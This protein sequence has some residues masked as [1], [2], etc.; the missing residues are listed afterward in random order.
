MKQEP[1]KIGWLLFLF[2]VIAYLLFLGERPI[3]RFD[4][5]RYAEIPREMIESSD[6]V[7]P[8]LNGVRYFEKPTLGYWLTALSIQLFG[9]N[10]FALRLVP[11]LSAGV[12]ALAVFWIASLQGIGGRLL[13]FASAAVLLSSPMFFALGTLNLLDMPL[14][15]FL[16]AGL[17]FFFAAYQAE[18]SS[19]RDRHLAL[20]GV[21]AGCAFLMKGFLGVVLPSLAI[22]PFLAWE[23]KLLAWLPRLW[24][25]LL[26]ACLLVLPWSLLIHARE[27]DFWR[28]FLWEEH[29]KRLLSQKAPHAN[30]SWYFIPVL[31]G[32]SFPWTFFLPAWVRGL[33]GS[34]REEPLLRFAFCA[35]ALPFLFF[36]LSSG[37]LSPY[38]LPCFPPLAILTGAG[39]LR[40]FDL[41]DRRSFHASACGVLFLALLG[42]LGLCLAQAAGFPFAP[43]RSGE[44]WK[45]VFACLSLV[46]FG[47]TAWWA[48]TVRKPVP[49]ILFLAVTPLLAMVCYQVAMPQA[50]EKEISPEE[51]LILHK[52]RVVPCGEIYAEKYLFHAVCWVY[53]RSDVILFDDAGELHYGLGYEDAKHRI[54]SFAKFNSMVREGRE[55]RLVTLVTRKRI[56]LEVKDQLP[57]P[58]YEAM[59]GGFVL[60]QYGPAQK[61]LQI[62]SQQ[63]HF[64]PWSTKVILTGSWPFPFPW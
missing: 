39:L 32:G 44:G 64:E 49:R 19:T 48:H 62:S 27:P 29:W 40:S 52:E 26:T 5:A 22:L 55:G 53:K 58:V 18:R 24:I 37:K 33:R 2:Y 43:Y 14:T 28:Y 4:E 31:L 47:G 16:T 59:D 13:G 9:E 41:G 8:R 12:S 45:W 51:F 46:S 42:A 21:A 23:R 57:H 61:V 63:V 7:V 30:S 50:V 60:S 11:A 20:L 10:R 25:P 6:W 1:R 56:Y 35:F 34:L 3:L 17:A 54:I 15:M 36:S 38:I